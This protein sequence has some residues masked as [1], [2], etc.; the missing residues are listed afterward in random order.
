M[1]EILKISISLNDSGK[2]LVIL[3]KNDVTLKISY[4][5]KNYFY[6]VFFFKIY[7][8]LLPLIILPFYFYFY[9]LKF[10]IVL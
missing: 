5:T 10:M 6:Y 9:F 3:K 2:M 8:F 4:I 1:L 7:Y